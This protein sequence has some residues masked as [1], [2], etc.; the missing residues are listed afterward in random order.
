MKNDFNNKTSAVFEGDV[1]NP[2]TNIW[3][4]LLIAFSTLIVAVA[5]LLLKFGVNRLSFD[6]NTI[7][8]SI[9]INIL[10]NI[11]L[12]IGCVGYVVAAI[13]LLI[14]LKQGELSVLFPI[15]SLSFVWVTILSFQFL[16]EL[17]TSFKLV[18]IV[19]I[20]IGVSLLGIGGRKW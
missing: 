12:I 2:K 10:T 1:M 17:M 7:F 9:S 6:V 5:Q 13:L 8:E 3:A 15:Y 16:N 18:G 19:I 11:P 4:I 20:V 14:S